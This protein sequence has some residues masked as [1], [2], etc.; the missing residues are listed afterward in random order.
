MRFPAHGFFVL[1][2]NKLNRE[3]R[4]SGKESDGGTRSVASQDNGADNAAPFS[5]KPLPNSRKVY[6][7]GKQHV[8]LRVPSFVMSSE[9]ETS[10]TISLI[11]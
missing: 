6:V 5:E 9:V 7:A 11:I 1:M 8:D 4:K 3:T 2:S 10:L